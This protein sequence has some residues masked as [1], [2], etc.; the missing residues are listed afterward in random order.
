MCWVSRDEHGGRKMYVSEA[1]KSGCLVMQK[2]Y[3][4]VSGKG[5]EPKSEEGDKAREPTW[6]GHQQMAK[7]PTTTRT[8]L[9]TLFLPLRLSALTLTPFH[10]LSNMQ[11]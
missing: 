5:G 4:S 8:S 11:T 10:N 9:V 2:A 3:I 7:T 1:W 6:M